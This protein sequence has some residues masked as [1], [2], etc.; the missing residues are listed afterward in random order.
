MPESQERSQKQE[1]QA[2]ARWVLHFSA[3]GPSFPSPRTAPPPRDR[4][5]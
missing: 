5:V 1:H 2:V 3:G 4:S